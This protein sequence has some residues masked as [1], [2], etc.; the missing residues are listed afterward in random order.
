MRST[1]LSQ[2]PNITSEEMLYLEHLTKNL[3]PDQLQTFILIY[4]GKRRTNDMMLLFCLLGL[5]LIPGIQRFVTGQIGMGFLYLFTV[6][7]CFIGSILDIVNYR[8]LAYEYN[9]KV[10]LEAIALVGFRNI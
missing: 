7:L 9:Q 2:I 4:N 10:A 3:S 8:N 6:G 1:F 5:I